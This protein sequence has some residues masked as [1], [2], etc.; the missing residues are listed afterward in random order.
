ML[1]RRL[2][3]ARM[4]KNLSRTK[5]MAKPL[6]VFLCLGLVL[7]GPGVRSAQVVRAQSDLVDIPVLPDT[8]LLFSG[9]W[10]G[11]KLRQAATA[12]DL[13]LTE[14]QFTSLE[15]FAVERSVNT[16][17]LL[18]IAKLKYAPDRKSVV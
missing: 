4:K 11:A 18:T 17:L 1:C 5:K 6:L 7:S 13:Q 9:D 3:H 8:L 10:Y 12:M 2:Y 15:S 16:R 14:E